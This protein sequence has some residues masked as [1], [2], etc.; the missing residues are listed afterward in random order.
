MENLL[1][2]LPQA[3]LGWFAENKRDLPWR[4]DREPYHVWVSEIML[5]QTRVEAVK[6]YYSRFL[7]ALPTVEALAGAEDDRLRKLWEGLGYYNRVR[8]MKKAAAVICNELGGSFPQ[9]LEGLLNL[10]GIGS[11]TAGAIGSI[12]F[13]LP[14]PAVDGNVLRVVS[15]LCA[16]ETPIDLPAQKK[17]VEAALQ[18]VYPAGHCGDFTQSLMELGAT[19]CLPNGKPKCADC[20]CKA[21]CLG[22]RQGEPERLPIRLPKK[23]RRQ[24]DKTVFVLCCD[25]FYAV[26]KRESTGLLASLWEFPNVPEH[27]ELTEAL[28][29]AQKQGAA[30][31]APTGMVERQHIFTHV[32][33]NMRCYYLNC[34][35]RPAQFTWVSPAQIAQEIAL[36]TAFKMFW[37]ILQA[38]ENKV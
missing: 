31:D 11:Y 10:P 9:T 18:K 4:T 12:A 32:Q 8:N 34:R 6:G 33:W 17:R 16:D 15:R 27:L 23:S 30:P 3:L 35:E 38:K 7:A 5:Q 36:P 20:P 25:G 14:A 19:V 37:D 13:E 29:W 24:E 21:F 22:L 28:E 1:Q 2:K 26:Q